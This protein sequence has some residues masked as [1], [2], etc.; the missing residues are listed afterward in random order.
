[1]PKGRRS[2]YP[3][4][5]PSAN[6]RA[7]NNAAIVVIR[8]GR[9]RNTHASKTTGRYQTGLDPYLNVMT[10]QLTLLSDQQTEVTPRVGDMAAAVQLIQALGGG[11]EAPQLPAPLQ[12]TSKEAS[13]QVANAP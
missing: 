4:P 9:K 10:V 11:W 5:V 2:S 7:P 12:I 3:V 8:I 6:G 1:M 13:R